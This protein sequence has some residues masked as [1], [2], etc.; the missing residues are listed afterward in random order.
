MNRL[1]G[2][3]YNPQ[4]SMSIIDWLEERKRRQKTI[5]NSA[6]LETEDAGEFEARIKRMPQPRSWSDYLLDPLDDGVE[7][8]PN[9]TE[10]QSRELFGINPSARV[11]QDAIVLQPWWKNRAM[12]GRED[13]SLMLYKGYV[14]DADIP[15]SRK[16]MEYFRPS[17]FTP[18][19]AGDV[20]PTS[21]NVFQDEDGR[22]IQPYQYDKWYKRLG[23]NMVQGPVGVLMMAV[24]GGG[25]LI[26]IAQV[27][28]RFFPSMAEAAVATTGEIV[29]EVVE[30]SKEVGKE[31]K[32]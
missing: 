30:S 25:A 8:L 31:L 24:M 28:K 23:A 4:Y 12:D 10:Q 7:L 11:N 15:F 14:L 6:P 2:Y 1:A 17:I 29:E 18:T 3:T 26:A 22:R 5:D 21:F 13:E 20:I 27:S 16:V 9:P 19:G 32:R